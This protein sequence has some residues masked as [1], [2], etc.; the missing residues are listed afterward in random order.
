MSSIVKLA[1]N[2]ASGRMGQ[3]LIKAAMHDARFSLVAASER[4][5]ALSL[6][7][8]D[9]SIALVTSPQELM[10]KAEAVIDFTTPSSSLALAEVAASRGGI[11]I[12]GTTGFSASEQH[13]IAELAKHARIVQ[14]GNFSLGVNLLSALVEQ[15]AKALDD[16][17]DI[18]LFEMHHK[19]KKDAPSGTALMLGR[20]AAKGR[21]VDFDS[22]K[23]LDRDGER[24]PGDIGFS[25]ARGGDVVGIHDVMFAGPG[26]TIT[27]SHQGFDRSIYAN[28]ALAAALWAKNQKPGLYSMRDVLG[29]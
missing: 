17:Y 25:V 23:K 10:A 4:A 20:S 15:A 3:T 6:L 21:S 28:G 18:E 7:S 13:K 8:L 16:H 22:K 9:E 12:I 29:F 24:R 14:S 5:E 1:I 2:G 19:H 26:E 27:L 11:H